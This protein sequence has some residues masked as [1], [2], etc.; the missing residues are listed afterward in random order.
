M[1]KS[2]TK[3]K[4]VQVHLTTL[5]HRRKIE[6]PQSMAIRRGSS[7]NSVR[8]AVRNAIQDSPE[9]SNVP[10]MASA[11]VDVVAAAAAAGSPLE[12]PS[13]KLVPSRASSCLS[14]PGACSCPR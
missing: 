3:D 7:S 4:I 1:R 14:H 10:M 13:P 12:H 11:A 2:L 5:V 9:D 6:T 8:I